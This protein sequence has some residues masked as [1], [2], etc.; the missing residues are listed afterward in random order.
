MDSQCNDDRNPSPSFYGKPTTSL[1]D[2]PRFMR[3]LRKARAELGAT[4]YGIGED[5]FRGQGRLPGFENDAAAPARISRK[6]SVEKGR[7]TI[8]DRL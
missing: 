5:H 7:E 4:G 3:R 1:R 6:G 2:N 8:L